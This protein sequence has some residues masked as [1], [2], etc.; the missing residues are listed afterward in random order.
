M[1]TIELMLGMLYVKPL[2]RCRA[3]VLKFNPSGVSVFI[4]RNEMK[5]FFFSILI[6]NFFRRFVSR[7]DV[8]DDG[9]TVE[10]LFS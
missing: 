5:R 3:N 4:E 10:N 9:M 6:E 1:V 2:I 7:S 8:G